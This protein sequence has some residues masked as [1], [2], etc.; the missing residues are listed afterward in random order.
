[1]CQSLYTYCNMCSG[2]SLVYSVLVKELVRCLWDDNCKSDAYPNIC[3]GYSRVLHAVSQL[4]LKPF[5]FWKAKTDLASLTMI[6]PTFYLLLGTRNEYVGFT[7]NWSMKAHF[8]WYVC[9]N[10]WL[11]GTCSKDEQTQDKSV[12]YIYR[13]VRVTTDLIKRKR[14][15]RRM[16]HI[17]NRGLTTTLTP[18]SENGTRNAK[19]KTFVRFLLNCIL[20]SGNAER[21]STYQNALQGSWWQTKGTAKTDMP[22]YTPLHGKGE[23][24]LR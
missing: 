15:E 4:P 23:G 6:N 9:L 16:Y 20:Q 2:L 14:P 21:N 10:A 7:T 11:S 22:G 1:M 17:Q 8:D 18:A 12:M 3:L 13:H 24:M 5:Q 19:I